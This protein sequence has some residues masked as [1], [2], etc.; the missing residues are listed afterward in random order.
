MNKHIYQQQQKNPS[1][2]QK[3]ICTWC[4]RRR[5]VSSYYR[6]LRQRVL[7]ERSGFSLAQ[8]HAL[9]TPYSGSPIQHQDCNHLRLYTVH[10]RIQIEESYH[11]QKS[12]ILRS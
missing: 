7:S 2:T 3:H 9:S 12:T 5:H 4:A 6:L 8:I 11:M 10:I 1:G